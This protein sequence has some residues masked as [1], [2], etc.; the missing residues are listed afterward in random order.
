VSAPLFFL[1]SG[2]RSKALRLTCCR[3]STGDSMASPGRPDDR[4]PHG[5]HD[6]QSLAGVENHIPPHDDDATAGACAAPSRD[7]RRPVPL[8][9]R[10]G[11]RASRWAGAY[12]VCRRT[13]AGALAQGPEATGGGRNARPYA[14]SR[15]LR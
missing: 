1:G 5:P 14:W 8:R 4:R 12:P 7:G 6:H 9:R 13:P 10:R 3:R 11:D 15:A 2:P